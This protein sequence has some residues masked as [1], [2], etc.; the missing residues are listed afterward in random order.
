V[1]VT[2]VPPSIK[3]LSISPTNPVR[4]GVPVKITGTF[5]DPGVLDT[6][7]VLID[8]GDG[9][10]TT[11]TLE[12]GINILSGS[13]VYATVGDYKI[14]V[15]L[16]DNDGGTSHASMQVFVK[17]PMT[18]TDGLRGIITGLKIPKGLKNNLLSILDN[19]P[20]I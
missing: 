14:A 15:T 5:S 2:N 10:S 7:T 11:D 18:S 16:R 1:A 6:H 8:W 19:I 3:S 12:A 4:P 13:H 9:T 20:H 17:S